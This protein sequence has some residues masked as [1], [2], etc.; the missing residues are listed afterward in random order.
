MISKIVFAMIRY[1]GEE[2]VTFDV[3]LQ[4]CCYGVGEGEEKYVKNYMPYH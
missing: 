2:M 4:G 1:V 3:L